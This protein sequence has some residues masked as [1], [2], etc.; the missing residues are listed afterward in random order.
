MLAPVLLAVL[1]I[2]PAPTTA[3]PA[4]GARTAT[5]RMGDVWYSPRRL[6]VRS[7][8]VVRWKTVGEAPHDVTVLTGPRHFTSPLVPS[9]TSWRKRFR[10]RGHYVL[11]CSIHGRRKMSMRLYVR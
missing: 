9:G 6:T 11:F 4:R 7:G 2:A 5:V 3:P 1:A 10:R 8:T